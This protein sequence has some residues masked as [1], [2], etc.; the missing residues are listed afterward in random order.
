MIRPVRGPAFPL[1]TSWWMAL[2]CAA[3]VLAVLGA[4]LWIIARF[5]GPTPTNDE[6]DAHALHLFV[7]YAESTL[8][9]EQ[10]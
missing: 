9:L 3:F 8:S 10:G 1:T 2:T 7:P 5:A 4:K 6:W